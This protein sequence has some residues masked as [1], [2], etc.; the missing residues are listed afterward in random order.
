MT[1]TLN[2]SDV[3]AIRPLAD[4]VRKLVAE[5]TRLQKRAGDEGE[6][7]TRLERDLARLEE[8]AG[9]R[10]TDD[11]D[12]F[13][14]YKVAHRR[15]T[16][17]LATSREIVET[18]NRKIIP[19]KRAEVDA[20]RA[21]SENAMLALYS[22]GKAD[23]E[24][25]MTVLLDAVVAEHDSFL[26]AIDQLGREFDVSLDYH[27]SRMPTPRAPHPR[28]ASVEVFINKAPQL[29]FSARP[30]QNAT[31]GPAVAPG[32]TITAEPGKDSQ[33]APEAG[34]TPEPAPIE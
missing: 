14:R 7:V 3:D 20:A 10:L 27:T 16:A 21:K 29:V 12:S 24:A 31:Q 22:K 11:R 1:T 18:F 9:E 19:T 2:N 34:P 15:L 6:T 13:E 5:L 32:A 30:A 28:L 8:T 17:A 26:D 23:C 33:D 25:S 4:T